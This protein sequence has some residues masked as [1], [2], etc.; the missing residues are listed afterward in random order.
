ML[1]RASVASAEFIRNIGYWQNEALRG[2]I[3]ITHHGRERLVLASASDFDGASNDSLAPYLTIFD[4][5]SE[6][7]L[8]FDSE[9][10]LLSANLAAQ[11]MALLNSGA[12]QVTSISDVSPELP[13]HV[14]DE[15]LFRARAKGA[16]QVLE[17]AGALGGSVQL[18]LIPANGVAVVLLSQTSAA[19]DTGVSTQPAVA[20]TAA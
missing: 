4:H 11:Q 3:S 18:R 15:A 20:R 6:A 16:V 12:R 13:K 2:P 1:K 17:Y 14:F 8:I 9:N 19:A 7:T 5:M 10:E